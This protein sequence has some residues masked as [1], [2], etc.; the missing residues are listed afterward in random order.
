MTAPATAAARNKAP[1]IWTYGIV[2]L[3]HR[4]LIVGL[5]LVAVVLSLIL[6]L[7]SPR[8]FVAPA[9]FVPQ[10]P[11]GA[12]SGLGQ[13][14]SQLGIAP[15]RGNT[16]SAQF[17]MDLLQSR[18][19][20]RSALLTN[21]RAP[22]D[23]PFAGTLLDYFGLQGA[24]TVRAVIRG[25]RD[26][27]G[28]LDVRGDRNTGLVRLEVRSTNPQLSTQ[29]A[30][31]FLELV[32][33]YNLRRRQSQAHAEREFVEQRL[34]SAQRALV[35]AEEALASFYR[36]NRRYTDSPELTADEAR[37]QRV[38]ALRQQLYLNLAQSHELAKIE[39]VRNTPV[40][41]V[42]EHPEGFVEPRA[43]GTIGKAAVTGILAVFFAAV[44]SFLI[45]YLRKARVESADEYREFTTLR[46][47]LGARVFR[48]TRHH[49]Q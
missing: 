49:G 41:T 47:T 30:A 32:N 17:Y 34:A 20:L 45:E 13:V 22:G 44:L 46:P 28:I 11:P 36:R 23:P 26:V 29:I 6:S 10:E 37:L 9:S 31:R 5:P 35:V 42:V 16:T 3:R 43:R 12:A 25:I 15:P 8:Q 24:D 48:L 14:A 27:R 40:I 7:S 2:V 1:T 39:E 38:V 33:D 4:A 18:E 21:Y 19:V